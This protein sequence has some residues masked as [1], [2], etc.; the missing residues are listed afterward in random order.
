MSQKIQ[1]FYSI[2][3]LENHFYVFYLQQIESFCDSAISSK[4]KAWDRQTDGQTG[5]TLNAGS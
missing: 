5:T 1:S 3:F 2:Q 4:S